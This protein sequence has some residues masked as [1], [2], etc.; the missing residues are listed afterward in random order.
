MEY[1]EEEVGSRQKAARKGRRAR[2]T[3][4]LGR[5]RDVPA[6]HLPQ[7]SSR[8]REGSW[9]AV[10]WAPGRSAVLGLISGRLE[11]G[12]EYLGRSWMSDV[13][14]GLLG[15]SVRNSLWA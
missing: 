4:A 14:T 10:L 3:E 7:G 6:T 2:A 9:A 13:F 8:E 12:I 1:S 11:R 15:A 5:R